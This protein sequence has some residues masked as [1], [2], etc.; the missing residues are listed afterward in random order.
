N[1]V[2]LISGGSAMATGA[3]PMVPPAMIPAV[4]GCYEEACAREGRSRHDVAR[5][6][7]AYVTEGSPT[8]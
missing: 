6:T 1:W 4:A 7:G 8:P 3:A 5:R 2:Q